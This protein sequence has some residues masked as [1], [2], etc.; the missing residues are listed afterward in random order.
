M[1]NNT[2][3]WKEFTLGD[4]QEEHPRRVAKRSRKPLLV[5]LIVAVLAVAAVTVA[6]LL[7]RSGFDGLR[8]KVIY[9]KAVKDENGCAQL[10]RYSSDQSGHF[11][12]LEG[13]LV[14]VS[15]HQLTVLDEQNKTLYDEAVKFQS[16]ALSVGGGR[17]AAYDVGGTVV[18]VLSD[19][20]L[21]YTLDCAGELLSASLNTKG[22]LTVVCSES[23]CKAAVRVYDGNG[24]AVFAFK[25]SDRFVMTAALSADSRT[26]AA[27]TMG[28]ENGTFASYVIFYRVN[29]DQEAGRCTLRGSVVYDLMAAGTGFCAVTEEQLCFIDGSGVMTAAYDYGGDYLRR[30]SI[31]GD[32][33]AALLLGRYRTGTQ[34]RVVTVNSDGQELAS[35]ELD[36]EVSSLSAAGRYVAVLCSDHLTIYDKQLLPV[37]ELEEVSQARE[38][39]MRSDGSAVL[40]G[41]TAASLTRIIVVVA[42]LL[43]AGWIAGKLAEPAARWL[44]PILSEKLEQ[45]LTAQGNTDD[46]GEMLAAFG[47]EGDT[48]SELVDNAVEKA[49]QAGETLLSAVVSTA[50]KSA[51]YAVVY[52]VSFLLLLLLLRLVLTPLHLFTKLPV[53]HGVNAL[54][55]GVLGLV[56]CALLL[57]LAVWVLQ[58]LQ[59]LVTPELVNKTVLLKFFAQNSPIDLIAKL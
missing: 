55:G 51:A 53:V 48:L 58:K 32:G 20:G 4:V 38:V 46:A 40:A 5:L 54:L 16:P 1:D 28:Q 59:L 18:Y 56:K 15:M 3:N 39:L 57:F 34:H 7:D 36:A 27:V 19:K 17:A 31:S 26:L 42:A 25:S 14:S 43:L 33:Y 6:V 44:E 45:R 30:V 24:E 41:S 8:R 21:M 13:S 50:L 29:S 23:G 12:S 49:Q 52:V 11:A 22:W 10:Y 9:A 37:A 47:F 2:N 35:L